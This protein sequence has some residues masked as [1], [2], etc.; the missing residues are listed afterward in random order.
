MAKAPHMWQCVWEQQILALG[1]VFRRAPDSP[2]RNL[3][4]DRFLQPRRLSGPRRPGLPRKCWYSH[5]LE[6]LQKL[7]SYSGFFQ[8]VQDEH[9]EF[10]HEQTCYTLAHDL[11]VWKKVAKVALDSPVFIPEGPAA[12]GPP[13][14]PRR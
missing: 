7:C 5:V 6:C 1:H 10:S 9:P 2:V 12:S 3:I 4:M 8:M 14:W 11:G 13:A